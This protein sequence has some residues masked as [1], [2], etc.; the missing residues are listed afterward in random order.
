MSDDVA[1]TPASSP[2]PVQASRDLLRWA[3]KVWEAGPTVDTR[4]F[5]A[6]V[7]QVMALRASDALRD[8]GQVVQLMREN[9]ELSRRADTDALTGLA[10][11]RVFDAALARECARAGRDR[12]PVALVMIDIDHFHELN[13]THGHPTGDRCLEAIA[14]V[15]AEEASRTTDL[16][17]RYGGEEFAI[18]LPGTTTDEAHALA[19]RIRTGIGGR[20]LIHLSKAISEHITVSVGV[21]AL[22][23]H[24]RLDPRV[25]LKLAD[26]ALLEAKRAGRDRVEHARAVDVAAQAQLQAELNPKQAVAAPSIGPLSL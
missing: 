6:A 20:C 17:C 11:R 9:A 22:V 13:N 14:Q 8:R 18:I 25:L 2:S 7:I 24:Q 23:P 16:A 21:A 3:K 4:A 10:N 19:E 12:T 1:V 15:V 5:A 26:D